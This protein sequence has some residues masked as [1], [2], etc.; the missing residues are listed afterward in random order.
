MTVL[1]QGA[2]AVGILVLERHI[3]VKHYLHGYLI[4]ITLFGRFFYTLDL[5]I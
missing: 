3:S 2:E 1:S 5:R 4:H